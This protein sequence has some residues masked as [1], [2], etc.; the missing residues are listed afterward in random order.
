MTDQALLTI[1]LFG[2][3]IVVLGLGVPIAIA[4]GGLTVVFIHFF[5]SDA[6]INLLPVRSFAVASSFEYLAVPLFVLMASVLQRSKIAE[7]MY[8]TMQVLF[9]RLRGG[10]A[11]GTIVI[12]TIFAAMAGISGAATIAMGVIAIPAMLERG[13]SKGLAVGSVAAGGSL[14]ILIPPSITMIVYGLVTG[15]SIGQLY[16]GGVGPGLLIAGMFCIYILYCGWR[17]PETV[18]GMPEDTGAPRPSKLKALR[19][20]ILPFVLIVLVLGSILGGFASISES[21]AVGAAGAMILA[22]LRGQMNGKVMGEALEETLTLSCMIFWIIIG[23]SALANF[24]TAMGAARVIEQAVL[25]LDANPWV[26]LICMQLTLLLMGMVLDSTGIILITA[27]IF[28][29]IAK[30]LGFDPVWFGVLYIINMEMGFLSPPF[31]YNLFY[32]R[33]VAPKSVRMVDI[34]RSVVPFLGLM[35]IAIALCMIFPG[36]VNWLPDQLFR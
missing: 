34:Y 5:W 27:P 12:C 7:D 1:L 20:I 19:G 6:A 36:I 13:Y 9:G 32:I 23:A 22:A 17:W 3:M 8:D 31:G 25:G 33:A 15:T 18:G 14:G 30:A 10:L 28:L 35:L 29:P 26:V 2:S 16:A 11:V 21:A 24:Y 4:L